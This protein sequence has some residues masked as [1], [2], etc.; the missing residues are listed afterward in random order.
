MC[1][2]PGY[3]RQTTSQGSFCDSPI[4]DRLTVTIGRYFLPKP[5]RN[6]CGGLMF[7]VFGIFA[8]ALGLAGFT[9][10]FGQWVRQRRF[11]EKVMKAIAAFSIVAGFSLIGHTVYSFWPQSTSYKFYQPPLQPLIAPLADVDPQ[12]PRR[13][14]SDNRKCST[15]FPGEARHQS[16]SL[17]PNVHDVAFIQDDRR[18]TYCVSRADCSTNDSAQR[19]SLDEFV[20]AYREHTLAFPIASDGTTRIVMAEE[21]VQDGVAGRR[22]DFQIGQ[23]YL[24]LTVTVPHNHCRQALHSVSV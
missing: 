20:E 13:F 2:D 16:L 21:L 7:A 1:A 4:S 19:P 18:E 8:I 17:S 5:G 24:L 11:N 9:A 14:F 6:A 22:T 23:H 12:N 10:E 15:E 3:P